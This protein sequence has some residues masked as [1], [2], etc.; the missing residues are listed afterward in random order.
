MTDQIRYRLTTLR[1]DARQDHRF[2]DSLADGL[3]YVEPIAMVCEEDA[4]YPGCY[5][6]FTKA[7]DVM[8]LN[9]AT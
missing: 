1:V 7:G 6:I 9:P 2:F 5:D 3:A 4:D 8:S